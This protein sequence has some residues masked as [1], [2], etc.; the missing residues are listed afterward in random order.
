MSDYL[1]FITGINYWP[2]RKAMY[3]W[4]HFDARE[5]EDD[6]QKLARFNFKIVRIFLTWED[7]QPGPDVVPLAAL[8]NL[9]KVADLSRANHLLLMPTFFCGHMSGVNWMPPWML[10]P[11]SFTGRFPVYS[12]H[13]LLNRQ[14]RNFY[15]DKEIIAAQQ[16]Q[17]EKVGEALAGHPALWAYDLGNESS[18]CAISPDRASARSWLAAMTAALKKFGDPTPIT[19]GMHAEDLEE[20]R[21]LWPQDAALYCDFLSMH[22]YPFYLKWASTLDAQVL[23]FLA[24]LTL[25]LGE[26]PVLLQEFGIPT[27]PVPPPGLPSPHLAG[28]KC[29]LWTES[30]GLTYYQNVLSLL[31]G[32]Q[33]MGALGWCY[34]DYH[35][36]LWNQPPLH[37]NPHERHFGLFRYDGSPKPAVRTFCA[38][39]TD[40]SNQPGTSGPGIWQPESIDRDEYYANTAYNL[41]QLY[42]DYKEKSKFN[43]D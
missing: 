4:K 42:Q 15:I 18:N 38:R 23:P 13:S 34:A 5:V 22:G 43:A 20:D 39:D 25:W 7:F 26:K 10:T 28:F 6:F 24:L 2:A 3:W 30:E 11:K 29:P 8:D 1:Q 31:R 32:A 19:L 17:L 16:W 9:K 41:V 21:Q 40:L 14:I 12:G 35:P 36:L 27:L 37:Q 33:V